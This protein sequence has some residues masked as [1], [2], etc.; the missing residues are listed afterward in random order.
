MSLS[1]LNKPTQKSQETLDLSFVYES[2]SKPEA[3]Y[4]LAN[5]M[6]GEGIGITPLYRTDLVQAQEAEY[7]SKIK[8]NEKLTLKD[9]VQKFGRG[10][11]MLNPLKYVAGA[12]N[13]AQRYVTDRFLTVGMSQE[14]FA[15]KGIDIDSRAGDLGLASAKQMTKQYEGLISKVGVKSIVE[16]SESVVDSKVE[17]YLKNQFTMIG[18]GLLITGQRA[19]ILTGLSQIAG[20]PS[21]EVLMKDI[22]DILNKK[23]TFS[24]CEV[25]TRLKNTMKKRLEIVKGQAQMMKLSSEVEGALDQSEVSE[26]TQKLINT[27]KEGAKG[28][29]IIKGDSRSTYTGSVGEFAQQSMKQVVKM[30]IG[31][32][33]Q[34]PVTS[35][36][37]LPGTLSG[38]SS[39]GQAADQNANYAALLNWAKSQGLNGAEIAS[40]MNIA[41]TDLQNKYDKSVDISNTKAPWA[42]AMRVIT[43]SEKFATGAKVVG[44]ASSMSQMLRQMASVENSGTKI[45]SNDELRALLGE[46]S[47]DSSIFNRSKI[48]EN[49]GKIAKVYAGNWVSGSV[50]GETAKISA[51]YGGV[52]MNSLSP[53]A[54]AHEGHSHSKPASSFSGE[55]PGQKFVKPDVSGHAFIKS[56]KEGKI[57][58]GTQSY[59]FIK[60]LKQAESNGQPLTEMEQR[61]LKTVKQIEGGETNVKIDNKNLKLVGSGEGVLKNGQVNPETLRRVTQFLMIEGIKEKAASLAK[62]NT[63][64]SSELSNQFELNTSGTIS[65]GIFGRNVANMDWVTTAKTGKEAFFDTNTSQSNP[66]SLIDDL[67]S[68]KTESQ[69]GRTGEGL[70]NYST[71]QD[72]DL[73]NSLSRQPKQ[74][75]NTSSVESL[76]PVVVNGIEYKPM[77]LNPDGIKSITSTLQESDFKTANVD[78]NAALQTTGETYTIKTADGKTLEYSALIDQQ[79]RIMV[80]KTPSGQIVTPN[81]E[82]F[83]GSNIGVERMVNGKSLSITPEELFE[84]GIPAADKTEAHPNRVLYRMETELQ[85]KSAK[86][87]IDKMQAVEAQILADF[88]DVIDK[89]KKIPA[90]DIKNRPTT[91]QFAIQYLNEN[92]RS[93]D[94]PALIKLMGQYK[95]ASNL[96]SESRQFLRVKSNV[97]EALGAF[98]YS[99]GGNYTEADKLFTGLDRTVSSMVQDTP[100]DKN[101]MVTENAIIDRTRLSGGAHGL[102]EVATVMGL[103]SEKMLTYTATL[104][105]LLQGKT[106]TLMSNTGAEQKVLDDMKSRLIVDGK[107]D[108]NLVTPKDIEIAQTLFE[109]I[110]KNYSR[111]TT[112]VRGT[113]VENQLNK[114][115]HTNFFRLVDQDVKQM[116][117]D[118]VLDAGNAEGVESLVTQKQTFGIDA[119]GTL[120]SSLMSGSISPQFFLTKKFRSGFVEG[121]KEDLAEVMKEGEKALKGG[122]KFLGVENIANIAAKTAISQGLSKVMGEVSQSIAQETF[123]GVTKM[124]PI[125][126]MVWGSGDEKPVTVSDAKILE[127]RDCLEKGENPLLSV[128]LTQAEEQ[129]IVA[130]F[131]KRAQGHGAGFQAI[132]TLSPEAAA[133]FAQMSSLNF[134]DEKSFLGG[135]ADFRGSNSEARS[136]RLK[137]LGLTSESKTE[138]MSMKEIREKGLLDQFFKQVKIIGKD[139]KSETHYVVNN[140]QGKSQFG[141]DIVNPFGDTTIEFVRTKDGGYEPISKSD[142]G[143][144]VLTPIHVAATVDQSGNIVVSEE[145]CE[146]E[147]TSK[148]LQ[149][150]LYRDEFISKVEEKASVINQGMLKTETGRE[151][152]DGMLEKTQSQLLEVAEYL[153]EA[154]K[155]LKEGK[156]V[157]EVISMLSDEDNSPALQK[158]GQAL[159]QKESEKPGSAA[160]YLDCWTDTQFVDRMQKYTFNENNKLG[161]SLSMKGFGIDKK[162]V[163]AGELETAL[164]LN[165]IDDCTGE[166]QPELT[167]II[168]EKTRQ[169]YNISAQVQASMIKGQKERPIEEPKQPEPIEPPV[170]QPAPPAQQPQEPQ[171][172]QPQPQ[173]PVVDPVK[174][175]EPIQVDQETPAP[176]AI[177]PSDSGIENPDVNPVTSEPYPVEPPS[178]GNPGEFI[179]P[180]GATQADVTVPSFP[181]ATNPSDVQIEQNQFGN[182]GSIDQAPVDTFTPIDNLPAPDVVNPPI[183]AGIVSEGTVDVVVPGTPIQP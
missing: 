180:D 147:E 13:W 110:E 85:Y 139:G 5:L 35:L 79:Q 78:Q 164:I 20:V 2:L 106:P 81:L 137:E 76:K 179:S 66:T 6:A 60:E 90:M 171:T 25:A 119:M 53:A 155:M 48:K 123:K 104:N 161:I 178:A 56:I 150:A 62:S 47:K 113:R 148:L 98:G 24:Q 11:S 102:S 125:S 46:F 71:S 173:D 84:K 72:A 15:K 174:E 3:Q 26:Q 42:A 4:A 43:S 58:D 105:L 152:I 87:A 169:Q 154:Q 118:Q 108:K 101:G 1:T 127:I 64:S 14:A 61:I 134:T 114:L 175:P 91:L 132:D 116:R 143:G 162:V 10:A 50:I 16:S 165:A 7:Q 28:T 44:D 135:Y 168:S 12:G 51:F 129:T 166:V 130:A 41:T 9:R 146:R 93:G 70:G 94:V 99:T 115:K 149:N 153:P 27:Q 32:F 136:M 163:G 31:L 128:D 17:M 69:F 21:T 95:E 141:T 22:R 23:K 57:V 133:K 142:C 103:S 18:K 157:E 172:P 37:T 52:M 140:Y 167:G 30:G 55:R 19:E 182:L 67:T 144:N 117:K 29:G 159:A 160:Q 80:F 183:D 38:V 100:F 177:N 170:D 126:V 8:S 121:T 65:G 39:L 59:E 83:K 75:Q 120:V 86:E 96:S 45:R 36:L 122:A 74:V 34:N 63:D 124:G 158:I 73:F 49:I 151:Q 89:A 181:A 82:A 109:Q 40:L 88:G 112:D 33:K 54:E 111:V 156:S 138:S 145:L 107:I 131:M 92:G 68:N 97:N 77:I 176:A